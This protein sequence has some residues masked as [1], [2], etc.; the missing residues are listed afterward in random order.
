M[1]TFS[2][3]LDFAKNF[4]GLFTDFAKNVINW[5][6]EDFTVLTFEGN[7]IEFLF[8]VGVPIIL[9]YLLL[10]GIFNVALG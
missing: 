6:L 5:L 9:S 8:G 10:K 2:N 4:L 3:L 1:N 7:K